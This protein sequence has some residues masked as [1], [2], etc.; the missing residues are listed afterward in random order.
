MSRQEDL[1]LR[2]G[3]L[4]GRKREGSTEDTEEQGGKG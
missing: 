1:M 3:S 2:A 4:V